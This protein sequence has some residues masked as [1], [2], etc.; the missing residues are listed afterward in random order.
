MNVS[1][2]V[3]PGL[4]STDRLVH[5]LRMCCNAAGV[6]PEQA[7]SDSRLRE[8]VLARQLYFWFARRLTTCRLREI[9]EVVKQSHSSVIHHLNMAKDYLKVKDAEFMK[10]YN[11]I[12]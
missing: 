8:V 5:I 2:Y 11:R 1:P 7:L 3:F 6:E 9:G 4:D 10:M 12:V